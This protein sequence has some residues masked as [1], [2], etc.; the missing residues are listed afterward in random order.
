MK[1]I[2]HEEC[3]YLFTGDGQVI[4]KIIGRNKCDCVHRLEYYCN[5]IDYIVEDYRSKLGTG[6]RCGF[7]KRYERLL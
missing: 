2:K 6:R 5:G 4:G 3:K 7:H 1:F